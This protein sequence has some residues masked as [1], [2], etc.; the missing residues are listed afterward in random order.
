MQCSYFKENTKRH[1]LMSLSTWETYPRFHK[2]V[3]MPAAVW[4]LLNPELQF[5]D[6]VD[7]SRPSCPARVIRPPWLWVGFIWGFLRVAH[8][9]VFKGPKFTA[10]FAKVP[11]SLGRENA[12]LDFRIC[13]L[14][15]TSEILMRWRG[16]HW[17]VCVGSVQMSGFSDTYYTAEAGVES[18]EFQL[19]QVLISEISKTILI[20]TYLKGESGLEQVNV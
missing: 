3:G 1:E 18:P 14:V 20:S 13:S 16:R 4:L 10:Q 19:W 8:L 11:D 9:C 2:W 5:S 17:H 15:L 12:T 6:C 7:V